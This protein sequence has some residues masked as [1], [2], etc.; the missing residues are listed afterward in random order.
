MRDQN[1]TTLL[2]WAV[3]NSYIEIV[4]VLIERGAE[5]NAVNNDGWTPLHPAAEIG[6]TEIVNALVKHGASV[7]AIG[8]NGWTPLHL[9]AS[10]GY[11]ETVKVLIEKGANVNKEDVAGWAPLHF[12]VMRG[13]EDV[14]EVL[15]EKG[16]DPLLKDKCGKTPIDWTKN[17]NM[18]NIL[19]KTTKGNLAENGNVTQPLMNF[20]E[21]VKDNILSIQ[22]CGAIDISAL[23][24][25]LQNKPNIT[26]LNL[27]DSNIGNEGVKELTKL[28]NITSLTLVDNNISDEGAKELTKLINLV[29]LDLLDNN[30]S[31]EG[32]KELT[33]LTNLTYLDLSENN[34]GDEGAKELVRLKKLTYLALSGNNISYK[35]AEELV[36][37]LVN[38]TDLL[39]NDANNENGNVEHTLEGVAETGSGCEHSEFSSNT[40]KSI[41]SNNNS[42]SMPVLKQES[43]IQD[44]N[45]QESGIQ[46]NNEQPSNLGKNSNTPHST[47]KNKLSIITVSTLTIA[48]VVSGVA[49]AVYL[50][51]LVVGTVVGACCLV[52]TGIVYYCNKPASLLKDS[53]VQEFPIRIPE[54][55]CPS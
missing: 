1:G 13:K 40:V 39:Y 51:M 41:K 49:I 23:V 20:N 42:V 44:N 12:A 48:G 32:I 36:D 35:V 54:S 45:E 28:T 47:Q 7:D 22:S 38:L 34:I 27:A 16:A 5:V 26:S 55:T 30:I 18:K 21:Y 14:A 53:N 8:C 10:D 2:H 31:D 3:S 4:N 24:S 43:G 17:Q 29:S 46:D 19:N 11:K 15:I 25:F 50:E 52:A 33:K 37:K 6:N 9:A